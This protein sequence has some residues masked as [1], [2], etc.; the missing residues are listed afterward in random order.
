[1]LKVVLGMVAIV[2]VLRLLEVEE[3]DPVLQVTDL[4]A[5]RNPVGRTE[6]AVLEGFVKDGDFFEHFGLGHNFLS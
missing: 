1:M 6:N 2:D 3:G 4:V 5:D